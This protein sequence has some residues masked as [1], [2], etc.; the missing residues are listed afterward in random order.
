MLLL[1]SL[2]FTILFIF[3]RTVP[4]CYT[5]PENLIAFAL[6]LCTIASISH[7]LLWTIET[8]G[9]LLWILVKYFIVKLMQFHIPHN[10]QVNKK[11]LEKYSDL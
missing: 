6:F 2:H 9:S 5:M 10:K 4:Y 1:N 7:I 11:I 8:I 3:S